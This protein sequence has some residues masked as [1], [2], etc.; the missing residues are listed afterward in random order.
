[1]VDHVSGILKRTSP[2]VVLAIAG[3]ALCAFAPVVSAESVE[4]GP[5][6]RNDWTISVA[7]YLWALSIDGELGLEGLHTDL[8]L[9]IYEILYGLSSMMM[10]D[11]SAHKGRFGLFINPL[12]ANLGDD[13]NQH[14]LEGTHPEA[15]HKRGHYAEDV[16]FWFWS[17]VS[18]GALCVG[19]PGER[20]NTGCDRG[21]LC[22]RPVDRH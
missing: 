19:R 7:P 15:E 1:M 5:L 12:Y 9:P 4:E 20:P 21:A 16:G 10:L 22:W 14:V 6:K 3:F 2:L 18:P 17:G 13:T 11:L 8:D